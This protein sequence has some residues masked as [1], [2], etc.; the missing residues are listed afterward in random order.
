MG[1]KTKAALRQFQQREG[2]QQSATLDRATMERLGA[3]GTQTG[4]SG[5][6]TGSGTSSGGSPSGTGGGTATDGTTST[7]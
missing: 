5:A 3:G 4:S 7:R 6:A 2:L 1:P